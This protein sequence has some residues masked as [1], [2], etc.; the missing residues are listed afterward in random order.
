MNL[1]NWLVQMTSIEAFI[2]GPREKVEKTTEHA[3]IQEARVRFL[4]PQAPN[5]HPRPIP[6]QDFLVANLQGSL[7]ASS[8]EQRTV[9]KQV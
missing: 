7:W 3:C 1:L 6:P 8:G 4:V 5:P 9:A 2:S